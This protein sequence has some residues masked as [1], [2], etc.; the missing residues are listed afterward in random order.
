LRQIG[1]AFTMH[2]GEHKNHVPTTGWIHSP[3]NATPA[4]LGDSA[5]QKYMYYTEGGTHRPLPM[6]AALATYMGQQLRTDTR[7]NLQEDMDSGPCREVW[8]CPTQARDGMLRGNMLQDQSG[9]AA[10]VI[11]SSYIFNEEPTGFATYGGYVRGR[12]N[13]N[14]MKMTSDTMMV[15]EGRPRD[16]DLGWLVL[17]A[18]QNGTTLSECFNKQP[19]PERAGL[20]IP[21]VDAGQPTNFDLGRHKNRIN[22]VFM[23]GHAETILVHPTPRVNPTRIRLSKTV[24]TS[25]PTGF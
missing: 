15:A 17:Y 25:P 21:Y 3:N 16:G 11:W 4:G 7:A 12:G 23:D 20:G 6:P 8:T 13:L 10:P 18:I 24:Y 22:V 2:A 5:R 19:D 14:R 9:W 1:Q